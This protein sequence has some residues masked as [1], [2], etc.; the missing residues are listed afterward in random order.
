MMKTVLTLA[1]MAASPLAA[2][3]FSL[4]QGCEAYATVQNRGCVVSHMFRCEADPAGHQQ[5]LQIISVV[6]IGWRS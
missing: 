2:Q 4:P 6:F 3:Q 1:V 5:H